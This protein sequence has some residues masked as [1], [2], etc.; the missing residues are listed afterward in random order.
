MR[1]QMVTF[2]IQLKKQPLVDETVLHANADLLTK[3]SNSSK[4]IQK[5]SSDRLLGTLQP[6][7][8]IPA[9][10][11]HSAS[12]ASRAPTTAQKSII[13]N[14][15]ELESRNC[16]FWVD[17]DDVKQSNQTQKVNMFFLC[18]HLRNWD[19]LGCPC[20]IELNQEFRWVHPCVYSKKN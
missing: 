6:L 3:S 7:D 18:S 16:W 20:R 12:W 2:S 9:P 4:A 13:A 17:A 19:N 8:R 5:F 10:C 15:I 1:S 14:A 11:S